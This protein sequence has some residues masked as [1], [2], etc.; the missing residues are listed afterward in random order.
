MF[1]R[2]ICLFGFHVL[3]DYKVVNYSAVGKEETKAL[4]II[5]KAADFRDI[6][7]S[8]ELT[9]INQF[10]SLYMRNIIWLK[11]KLGNRMK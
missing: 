3:Q 8:N 11:E 1:H 2:F 10:K 9:M 6:G 7:R 4:C 5:C